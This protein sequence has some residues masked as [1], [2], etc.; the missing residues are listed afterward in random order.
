MTSLVCWYC[1]QESDP[2]QAVSCPWCGAPIVRPKASHS[3]W[4]EQPM[5]AS[6]TQL[7]CG[8]INCQITGS[9]VPVAEFGLPADERVYFSPK[10][11][12]WADAVTTLAPS[13]RGSGGMMEARGPGHVGVS[14]N[15]AGKLIAVSLPPRRSIQGR[16]DGTRI[17]DGAL[18][19]D[20][21]HV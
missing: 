15:G 5:I 20:L 12:L 9:Y 18:S 6:M 17:S 1:R 2:D 21:H 16:G 19:P 4:M 13:S 10:V 8:A 7:S 11:L 14:E 3:G